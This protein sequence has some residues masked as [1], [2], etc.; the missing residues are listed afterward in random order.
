MGMP[1]E[2]SAIYEVFGIGYLGILNG[3]VRDVLGLNAAL[4]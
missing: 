4:I 3:Q 1:I 2:C